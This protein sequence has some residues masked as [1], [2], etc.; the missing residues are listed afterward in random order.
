MKKDTGIKNFENWKM[1]FLDYNDVE[2]GVRGYDSCL[3]IIISFLINV[4]YDL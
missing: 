1:R 2:Y 4:N 3:D